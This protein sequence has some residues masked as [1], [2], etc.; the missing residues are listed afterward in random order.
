[1]LQ[2]I[3]IVSLKLQDGGLGI[4]LNDNPDVKLSLVGQC[5]MFVFGWAHHGSTL[6]LT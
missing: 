6:A 3:A 1:M 4:R 5:L 2:Y